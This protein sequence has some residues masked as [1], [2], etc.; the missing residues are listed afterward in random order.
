MAP[1]RDAIGVELADVTSRD[2]GLFCD[3]IAHAAVS[4]IAAH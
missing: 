4:R 3:G 2:W 1:A